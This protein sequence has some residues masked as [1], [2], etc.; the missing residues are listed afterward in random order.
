MPGAH[1]L[2]AGR[3]GVTLYVTRRTANM[4]SVIDLRSRTYRDL[5]P[6]GLPDTLRLAATDRRL[7][8]G[9]RTSPAQLA[10]ANT[11]SAAYAVVNLGP[12]ADASTIGGHQW[13]SPDGRF[14]FAAYEGGSNPGLAVVDH[15]LGD[16]V[17]ATLGVPGQASRR[18]LRPRAR[19]PL[20]PRRRRRGVK[21][22]GWVGAKLGAHPPKEGRCR[23]T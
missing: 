6:L 18:R 12:A 21:T 13:T 1:E 20:R 5:F 11:L 9:L 23:R 14:T 4:M 16:R 3:D 22:Q 10:D 8:I 17:V 7:T 19:I 15:R 2:A